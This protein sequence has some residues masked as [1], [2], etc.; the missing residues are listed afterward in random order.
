MDSIISF[1]ISVAIFGGLAAV[2]YFIIKG[3]IS[4]AKK[5]LEMKRWA[6]SQGYA[7]PK[8]TGVFG[9]FLIIIAYMIFILPG[10][11]L[12]IAAIRRDQNYEK[13][14]RVLMNKWIDA[15][16]PLPPTE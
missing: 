2:I 6:K 15:G 9:I 11:I 3:K 10:I 13:E 16:K 8:K 12:T 7:L 4:N 14:M 5:W 1:L